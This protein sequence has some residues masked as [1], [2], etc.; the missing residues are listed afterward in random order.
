MFYKILV[1]IAI[2]SMACF[3]VRGDVVIEDEISKEQ[4]RYVEPT[5]IVPLKNIRVIREDDANRFAKPVVHRSSGYSN[6]DY[7]PNGSIVDVALSQL[8]NEGGDKF[9]SWYGFDSHAAWCACFV[10]WCA[11]Q[12]GYIDAGIIPKF[13]LCQ[14]GA[15]WF[16]EQGLWLG[17]SATPE[18]GMLIFFDYSGTASEANHVGIVEKVEGNY[19]YVIDGNSHDMVR[20][21][22]YDIG[23]Y[24]IMGYGT[25]RY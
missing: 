19:I 1:V 6:Y 5:K 14:N 7:V 8:G 3:Q 20:E 13:A 12:C 16:M 21:N 24:D 2:F 4:I 22:V 18:P 15:V 25:P 23:E 11:N 17:G 10:S 9:W